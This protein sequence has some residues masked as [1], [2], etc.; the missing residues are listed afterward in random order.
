MKQQ[1]KLRIALPKGALFD[2]SRE[3]LAKVGYGFADPE[4]KLIFDTDN[5][6]L[7]V[8]LVKPIDVPVYVENGAADVGIV[9]SDVL[10]EEQAKVLTLVSLPYGHCDL[11]VAVPKDSPI[12]EI[13]QTPNYCRIATKFPR[14]AKQFFRKLGVPVELI[15]LN[16]SIEIA[17][18]TE[19]SEAIV[20]LVAT[21]RTLRENG[22]IQIEKI[23]SHSA[24]FISNRVSWQLHHEWITNLIAGFNLK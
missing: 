7:E 13:S 22:L 21:G 20:D 5:S 17:P 2:D 6:E 18:L 4:R 3:L 16:G 10:G 15:H 9:G 24:R 12:Q 19:L 11:V 14:L 1:R 23:S 8:M